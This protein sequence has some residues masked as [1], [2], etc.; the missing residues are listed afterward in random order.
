MD[1]ETSEIAKLTGRISQD[2]NSKLFVPLA[3][4]YKKAGELEMAIH[5]LLEGL[6]HNPDYV[7]ARSSLGK[8]LLAKGDITGAQM[9]FE[10]VVKHI[11]DNLMAQKKLGD[12]FVV[13]KRPQDALPHYKIALSLNPSDG[14][15]SS[16]ISDIEMGRDISS[17]VQLTKPTTPVEH[18]IKQT[19]QA[20]SVV[21]EPVSP[22]VSDQDSTVEP[23]THMEPP[24]VVPEMSPE[25]LAVAARTLVASVTDIEEAEEILIVEPLEPE[26][27][28]P[29]LLVHGFDDVGQQASEVL[30]LI[31]AELDH[32]SE[33]SEPRLVQDEPAVGNEIRPE[34]DLYPVEDV[35]TL[36]PSISDEANAG[37]I[38]D[39]AFGE[40]FNEK[41]PEVTLEDVSEETDDFTTDTLAELYIAQGFF[42]KAIEIYERMLT[43][44]PTSQG[45]KDKLAWVRAAAAQSAAP[46]AGNNKQ[47]VIQVGQ[48]VRGHDAVA[49]TDEGAGEPS[50]FDE[51]EGSRLNQESGTEEVD[52]GVISDATGYVPMVVPDEITTQFGD[53]EQPGEF[54]PE[55]PLPIEDLF[56]ESSEYK[57]ASEASQPPTPGESELF[58]AV[59]AET[60][61]PDEALD[62]SQY[63]EFEPR[64][65]IPTQEKIK[66]P[67]PTS[68]KV[69]A[70]ANADT[71][72]RKETIAR[73]ESWL[74]NIKKE[75]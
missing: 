56:T 8:L 10:E 32:D 28:G 33:V 16:L 1:K 62:K 46:F 43:D 3:E 23:I 60:A 7:T 22:L 38:I 21:R 25:P 20:P 26:A 29:E 11:P 14:E 12:I 74:T 6:K 58:G 61:V 71:T 72:G 4:E 67:K 31:G 70:T 39:A 66:P 24:P 44:N 35:E 63:L 57:P 2:P 41:A 27:P 55:E 15:L 65:Y 5:V 73:L 69:Q 51:L 54:Q 64:E 49:E 37:D 34:T 53:L 45:L 30:P 13:Q 50:I 36:Q 42:E 47:P 59:S 48:E 9:E 19:P 52:L 18:A 68:E 17:H 40:E 75:K